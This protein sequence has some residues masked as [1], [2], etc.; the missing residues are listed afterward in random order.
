MAVTTNGSIATS[1]ITANLTGGVAHTFN[2]TCPA[3]TTCL[4]FAEAN[5]AVSGTSTVSALTYDALGSVGGPFSLTQVSG[6]SSVG[7]G[8]ATD[9]C[10]IWYL[11]AP[12][13]GSS[14]QFSIKYNNTLGQ[15]LNMMVPLIGTATFG[16]VTGTAAT[17][18]AHNTTTPSVT[19]T[20]GGAND[21]YL[22]IALA[23]VASITSTG[24]NQTSLGT[25]VCRSST[26]SSLDDI[27]GNN[28]GAFTWSVAS[29]NWVT[30][31]V[32]FLAPTAVDTLM[33]QAVL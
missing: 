31:G 32:V 18:A 2:Y 5:G 19:A 30:S 4:V 29:T 10:S 27:T 16:T 9:E 3:S 20:G 7:V 24:A 1:T 25:L 6:S 23:E 8:G 17:G 15:L 28:A 26:I 13:T 14:L 21:L 33:G 11:L 22:A 12:P